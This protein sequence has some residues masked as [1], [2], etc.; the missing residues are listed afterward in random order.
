MQLSTGHWHCIRY[1][2]TRIDIGYAPSCSNTTI[3]Q[4]H[5]H[6][7]E[8]MA[9]ILS[10]SL[11]ITD[12]SVNRRN[13]ADR[14]MSHSF[15]SPRHGPSCGC[16][17]YGYHIDLDFVRYCEVLTQEPKEPGASQSQRQRRDRRRQRRS[18]EVMLG[19]EQ[20]V[21]MQQAQ[22]HSPLYEV[23]LLRT[24]WVLYL[25][26]NYNYIIHKVNDGEME[27]SIHNNCKFP[28]ESYPNRRSLDRTLSWTSSQG[29]SLQSP[30][31]HP[32]P[33][34]S[35]NVPRDTYKSVIEEMGKK[36]VCVLSWILC[37]F[38]FF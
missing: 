24:R 30:Y 26:I 4:H 12:A 34:R 31:L 29:D 7:A 3:T 27:E 38:F 9:Q 6:A 11:P 8:K 32:K 18:M 22:V 19:F 13:N 33:P 37:V 21:E 23:R 35:R 36:N 1:L 10:A 5:P 2:A 28:E 14:I 20:I 16:C 17:P 25:Y 15:T